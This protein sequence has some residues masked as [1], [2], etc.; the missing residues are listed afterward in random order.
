MVHIY[1][2]HATLRYS[3]IVHVS[4]NGWLMHHHAKMMRYH[5]NHMTCRILLPRISLDVD[6]TLSIFEGWVRELD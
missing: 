5:A 3:C 4:D 1:D 2:Y 6:Q